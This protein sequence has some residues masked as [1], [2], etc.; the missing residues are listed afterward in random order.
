MWPELPDDGN[1]GATD[2]GELR[3]GGRT[4]KPRSAGNEVDDDTPEFAGPNEP[5]VGKGADGC[6]AGARRLFGT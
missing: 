5:R 1:P 6:G 3:A 2:T 4:E